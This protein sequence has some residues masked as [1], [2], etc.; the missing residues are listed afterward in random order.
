MQY[1][2]T[3]LTGW[4]ASPLQEGREE[5]GTYHMFSLIR[6][7]RDYSWELWSA[8]LIMSIVIK[9]EMEGP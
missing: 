2:G 3:S 8:P 7:G 5:T 1:N 9:S 6:K 4:F